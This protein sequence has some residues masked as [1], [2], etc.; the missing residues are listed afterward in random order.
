MSDTHLLPGNTLL[1]RRLCVSL[2]SAELLTLCAS[3]LVTFCCCC[4]LS[5]SCP[6]SCSAY[7]TT[8]MGR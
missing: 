8:F 5:R 7:S 4:K 6:S 2:K 3:C 1:L